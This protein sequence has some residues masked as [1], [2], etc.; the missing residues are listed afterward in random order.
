MRKTGRV[1]LQKSVGF[2]FLVLVWGSSALFGQDGD[3]ITFEMKLRGEKFVVDE[4]FRVEF[5]MNGDG[6]NFKPP[7]FE[8]CTQVNG[9]S[10]SIASSKIKGKRIFLKSYSYTLKPAAQGNFTIGQATI[11]FKGRLIKRFLEKYG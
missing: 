1:Q 2:L 8:G 3:A 6:E 4:R 11:D 9:P 10:Q 7:S 5:N